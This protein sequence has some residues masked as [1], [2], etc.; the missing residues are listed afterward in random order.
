VTAQD[1]WAVVDERRRKRALQARGQSQPDEFSSL[2]ELDKKLTS[3]I[4][5]DL[6]REEKDQAI[7]LAREGEGG[8]ESPL[9][10]ALNIVS[11]P[12]SVAS[13]VIGTAAKAGSNA[14]YGSQPGDPGHYEDA[15]LE[16]AIQ[17]IQDNDGMSSLLEDSD[18]GQSL[19][20][21]VKIPLGFAADVGADPLT[22]VMPASAIEKIGGKG[23]ARVAMNAGEKELG[24]K[25]LTEGFA[26]LSKVER[27]QLEDIAK[28]D[29][30]I[31]PTAS[32]E[33]G[34]YARLPWQEGGI[35]LWGGGDTLSAKAAA[36][37][38]KWGKRGLNGA[39]IEPARKALGGDPTK[40]ALREMIR[41]G[42]ADTAYN[43]FQAL[44]GLGREAMTKSQLGVEFGS[45]LDEL[46]K[47]FK[48]A[49]VK[50]S[51]LTLILEGA[52]PTEVLSRMAPDAAAAVGADVR[53]FDDLVRTAANEA[54]GREFIKWRVDHAPAQVTDE[55]K[56]AFGQPRPADE[57]GM[58]GFA[59]GGQ[60]R[61]ATIVPGATWNN[62]TILPMNQAQL[63]E[64][65][66]QA[67]D[68][69]RYAASQVDETVRNEAMDK[70]T[71]LRS[72]ELHPDKL[73]PRQQATQ[74]LHRNNYDKL[75]AQA[76][77]DGD[78]EVLADLN[79]L[80]D[81]WKSSDVV[82]I[83]DDDWY[84]ASRAQAKSA[85]NRAGKV[86]LEEFLKSKGVA[87]DVW[88]TVDE[89]T[90][91]ALRAQELRESLA[92]LSVKSKRWAARG[93]RAV[94]AGKAAERVAV[95]SDP[96]AAAA[97][98][99]TRAL[100]EEQLGVRAGERAADFGAKADKASAMITERAEATRQLS[101][102]QGE[103]YD[104]ALRDVTAGK[105]VSSKLRSEVDQVNGE[106]AA[107]MPSPE[108]AKAALADLD[109]ADQANSRVLGPLEQEL[110]G[111]EDLLR[112][113]D[114]IEDG[115]EFD[116]LQDDI[117][118]LRER[119]ATLQAVSNDIATHRSTIEQQLAAIRNDDQAVID[120]VRR[121]D[122]PTPDVAA[123]RVTADK[124]T[125]LLVKHGVDVEG[126]SPKAL[127]REA[128]KLQTTLD[129]G[130]DPAT[131]TDT[132]QSAV[133]TLDEARQGFDESIARLQEK[134]GTFKKGEERALREQARQEQVAVNLF[135]EADRLD[136]WAN[137][138]A[139]ADQV[140][141]AQEL[142]RVARLEAQAHHADV[143]MAKLYNK[144]ITLENGIAELADSPQLQEAF[145]DVM[146]DGW[147]KLSK[148]T[149][150]PQELVE[151]LHQ[152]SRFTKPE[153]VGRMMK[154]FMWMGD[155]FRR[156]ALLTPGFHF[157]NLIG[158]LFNSYLGG[159]TQEV[160]EA[161]LHADDVFYRG[162]RDHGLD[163]AAALERA[164][165][166]LKPE[167][168]G[169]YAE[170][171][172]S[173][174]LDIH[175][176][177]SD[178]MSLADR[179]NRTFADRIGDD[180]VVKGVAKRLGDTALNNTA[181]RFS[182]H[183]G[184]D[185]ERGLRGALAMQAMV[186]GVGLDGAFERVAKYH[187]DYSDLSPFEEKIKHIVPFYTWTRKNL[188]LQIEGMLRKPR[189]Y[190]RYMSAKRSV[191]ATNEEEGLVPSWY[192][193]TLTIHLGDGNYL[194]PELP[195]KDLNVLGN[196]QQALGM[197]SPVIKTPIE[198]LMG[199]RVYNGQE[200]R[201]GYTKVPGAYESMGLGRGL[202]TLGLATRGTD[203]ELMA[204]ESTLYGVEQFM[205]L[206]GRAR[207]LFPDEEK[208]QQR[209]TTSYLSIMFG[210]GAR[211]N[212]EVDQ[213]NEL[214]ARARGLDRLAEDAYTLGHDTY[215][216]VEV[217]SGRPKTPEERAAAKTPHGKV[218][219]RRAK[220][221]EQLRGTNGSPS[222]R[223][224]SALLDY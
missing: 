79:E 166:K 199:K 104:Q 171:N 13:A 87:A 83:F 72:L 161:F 119:H 131:Q 175:G 27:L 106:L 214:W 71:K 25:I 12:L 91:A 140:G 59:P 125:D 97:D 4:E 101:A 136:Q 17:H 134:R 174:L 40:F 115:F 20:T 163:R 2:S 216:R 218:L 212:T 29:G 141:R 157:R 120:A 124:T 164:T 181:L 192:K 94:T 203:G 187:F 137:A 75:V 38:T 220:R 16:G 24:Q 213:E 61:Q 112:R 196:P 167:W 127:K 114:P 123:P 77:K 168:R 85:A 145:L 37:A 46:D 195:F 28:A 54:G 50:G 122:N 151:V 109:L 92:K 198:I 108:D 217:D 116:S 179:K 129:L 221:Q 62:E 8:S 128:I 105:P 121:A 95:A 183:V 19:P 193:D 82:D 186:D 111:A 84:K 118:A 74:I 33:G 148:S 48:S 224:L 159:Q 44:D 36:G 135:E 39:L 182:R 201:P 170:L 110:N 30:L 55:F 156:Y 210:V 7:D 11:K 80:R 204:R 86:Q 88:K 18:I 31:K 26:S 169:H 133:R 42:D 52:D 107:A 100:H 68:W 89:A 67:M 144:S 160:M 126:L 5:S 150:A 76:T 205:P 208:Y 35:K 1:P 155:L 41:T 49:G 173:G 142:A 51:E 194:F 207:R 58:G 43:A 154:S 96:G 165:M 56:D 189:M 146:R 190:S 22:Y 152:A 64:L 47:G 63:D 206:L 188:P 178:L 73:T 197:V 9:E 32:L 209:L 65:E 202:E 184:D 81:V 149:Q 162:M 69:E 223:Y 211:T 93:T 10:K 70:A 215:R 180:G 138:G 90:P 191:E 158:G 98:L 6:S 14:M 176:Q 15:N 78:V 139:T 57:R 102:R 66:R 23:F 219:A 200:F 117:A 222:E 60:E 53:R 34:A 103:L 99:L 172:R 177:A 21:A 130:L 113:T 132:V 185:V 45:Q 147:S 3:I 143:K 153:D